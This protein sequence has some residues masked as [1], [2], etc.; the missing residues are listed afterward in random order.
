MKLS[1]NIKLDKILDSA[2]LA[3]SL[4]DEDLQVVSSYVRAGYDADKLSR[5]GWEAQLDM[6]MEL[7]LQTHEDKSYPW[8]GA[9]SVKYPLI[10]TAAM[11]FSARAYAALLPG[12]NLVKGRPIGFDYDGK[13][14][15]TAIRLSK[16]MSYQ[17]L[18]EMDDWEEQMD[19]LLFSLPILGCMFKKTYFDAVTAKNVSEVIYPKELVVNYFTDTLENATRVSHDLYM[20]ENDIFER[21]RAGV[22]RDCDLVKNLDELQTRISEMDVGI[23]KPMEEDCTTPYHIVEQHTYLDLDGDGYKEP[24]VVTFDYNSEQILRIVARFSEEDIINNED[25]KLQSIRATQYFTKFSFVPSPDGSFYDVGFG[26]ILGPINRTINTLVNQLLDAGTMSNLQSGFISSGVRIKSGDKPFKPGEWK[27]VNTGV[28]DLGK[29]LFPLPVREPSAVL[30]NLLSMMITAGERL[31]SVA[32]VMT[33]DIPGQ[34]TKATVAMAAIEQGMKVFSSIYKRVHR[35]L[36]KEYKKLFRLNAMFLDEQTYFTILDANVEGSEPA[37]VFKADYDAS[38]INVVPAS[39]PTIA[40][41][42]QKLMKVQALGELAAAGLINPQE[43]VKRYLEATEM[44]N[45]AALLEM[46][47]RGPS[48][49]EI[50]MQH[51]MAKWQKDYDLE[52]RRLDLEEL[53]IHAQALKD[54]ADAEAA[55]EGNQLQ[56]YKDFLSGIQE[57]QKIRRSEEQHR[58]KMAQNDQA[59]RQKQELQQQQA[60]Q[61][62]QL[63][64]QGGQNGAGTGTGSNR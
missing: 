44:P 50:Q 24:Y 46:P 22:F 52:E 4:S 11:Q 32:E 2:N 9:A 3:E 64:A 62:M 21:M 19:R 15:E 10:T 37:E 13:K 38:S 28:E 51:E 56:E 48:P 63:A 35:S 6:W 14:L 5:E 23:E 34:N 20:T 8:P 29:G 43:Y 49:E 16:H 25:G 36:A 45:P 31:S 59:F 40:S 7:A 57:Q 33:G 39:D 54:I 55:E 30:L 1:K 53:K 26:T 41:E 58:Q 42:E 18:E 12:T 60:Q 17:L 27:V 47:E 61:K